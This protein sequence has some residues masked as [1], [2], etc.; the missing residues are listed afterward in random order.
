M[1]VNGKEIALSSNHKLLDFL[2]INQYDPQKI[3]IER[4]GEIVP[5]SAY[6]QVILDNEDRLE[7]VSFV[8][9]G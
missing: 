7:I 6:H 1:R 8:G 2:E 9:G 3:A 5:K 4:N